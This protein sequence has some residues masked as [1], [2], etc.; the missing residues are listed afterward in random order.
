MTNCPVCARDAELIE[1]DICGERFCHECYGK[2]KEKEKF[3]L[4]NY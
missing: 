3:L 2:H 1:C 4:L